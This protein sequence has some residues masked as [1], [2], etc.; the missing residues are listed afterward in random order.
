VLVN[1]NF[2]VSIPEEIK[3]E[4]EKFQEVNWSNIVRKS[5]Q[6][7]LQARQ[8]PVPL[9]DF[10]ARD[11][12]VCF[13]GWRPYVYAIVNATNKLPNDVIID[14]ILFRM[15]VIKQHN[16]FGSNESTS[17]E[18]AGFEGYFLEYRLLKPGEPSP[19]QLLVHPSV[20]F[21]R[22][23]TES[24]SSTFILDITLKVFVQGFTNP[25][26]TSKIMTKVPIDEWK[27]EVEGVLSSYCRNWNFKQN[28]QTQF[29]KNQQSAEETDS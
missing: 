3:N 1:V 26:N 11:V 28:E 20:E 5:I 10:D 25:I 9:I 19:I 27:R 12:H 14:R 21:L 22:R 18:S 6:T 17:F 23:V 4:M 8:N 13:Q 7:Y 15:E 24:L 16:T 29:I 2:T